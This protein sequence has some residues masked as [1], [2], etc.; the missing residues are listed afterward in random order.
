MAIR[1]P[2]MSAQQARHLA[3]VR[4]AAL[5]NDLP[6]DRID[7]ETKDALTKL[8]PPT[9]LAQTSALT[10]PTSR[11]S[12]EDEKQPAVQVFLS[13]PLP[14]KGVSSSFDFLSRQYSPAKA[15][16]MVLR[17][18]LDDYE[19]LL[20]AGGFEAQPAEYPVET[21]SARVPTIQTS[22]IMRTVLLD[23]ARAYFDPLDFES[24]RAFGR[25]LACAALAA[26]FAAEARR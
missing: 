1:K 26:F 2:S 13:A 16:R 23:R 17:R 19:A 9:T 24:N 21:A 11:Q 7:I 4:N 12:T 15:L 18:A 20:E 8:A 22:R 5:N 10:Q 14:A 3:K 6:L 25:K